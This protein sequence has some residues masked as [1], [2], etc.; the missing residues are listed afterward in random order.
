MYARSDL[1]VRNFSVA[2]LP[3][4][5]STIVTGREAIRVKISLDGSALVITNMY[6]SPAEVC[7]VQD[8]APLLDPDE[9]ASQ[10]V[11]GD[12]NG[13]DG[14]WDMFLEQDARG[15]MLA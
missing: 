9:D 13:H 1:A 4:P 12:A 3:P 6:L 5:C 14:L 15:K 2:R 11:V 10:L 8:L 7:T